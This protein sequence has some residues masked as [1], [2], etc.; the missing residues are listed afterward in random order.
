[1]GGLGLGERKSGTGEPAALRLACASRKAATEMRC[2]ESELTL[3]PRGR[4]LGGGASDELEGEGGLTCR[5][6]LRL[7]EWVSEVLE[8]SWARVEDSLWGEEGEDLAQAKSE[9]RR[10]GGASDVDS[11]GRDRVESAPLGSP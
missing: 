10:G 11:V 2:E 1:M 4:G 5:K 6:D 9:G 3:A 7:K 8:E